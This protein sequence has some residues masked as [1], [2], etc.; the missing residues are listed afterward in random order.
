MIK[1]GVADDWIRAGLSGCLERYQT[2]NVGILASAAMTV[3][4]LKSD[5]LLNVKLA[6]L[7]LA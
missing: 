7:N 1:R 4:R 3:N 5:A 2:V 6:A